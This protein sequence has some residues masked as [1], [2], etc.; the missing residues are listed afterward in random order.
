V[1]FTDLTRANARVIPLGSLSEVMLPHIHGLALKARSVLGPDELELVA[2]LIRV[3]L[4]NPF[5]FLRGEFDLAWEKAG[6]GKAIDFLAGR[7][8]SSL[9][10][11]APTDYSERHWLLGRHWPARHEAVEGK[12][13]AAVDSEFA[14]L[15][16]R[17]GSQV[18]A[19]RK[20]IESE[21]REAA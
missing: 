9:S 21:S 6:L 19:P 17:Y 14:E 18:D 11:L 2:P 7:H 15:L 13:S 20:V 3:R 10:V 1:Y 4:T 8:A 5:A 16:K 12:L